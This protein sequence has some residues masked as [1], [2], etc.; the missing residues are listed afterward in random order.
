[1]TIEPSGP[2]AVPLDNIATRYLD[3]WQDNLRHWAT[4]P[5]ALDKWLAETA[6]LMKSPDKNTPE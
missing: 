3:L 4:D 5:D 2:L 6:R 1:P